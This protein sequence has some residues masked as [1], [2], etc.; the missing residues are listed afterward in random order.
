MRLFNG[1]WEKD[2]V[3]FMERHIQTRDTAV[4]EYQKKGSCAFVENILAKRGLLVWEMLVIEDLYYYYTHGQFYRMEDEVEEYLRAQIK[5]YPITEKE[6][7]TIKNVQAMGREAHRLYV[8]TLE[9]K[10]VSLSKEHETYRQKVSALRE[11]ENMQAQALLTAASEQAEMILQ[12]ARASA[13][14][15]LQNAQKEAME[16]VEACKADANV[17]ARKY[18]S[19]H[20]QQMR[21]ECGALMADY[22]ADCKENAGKTDDLHK[23]MC[24]CTSELQAAWASKLDETFDALTKLKFDLYTNLREWQNTLCGHEYRAIAQCYRDLYRILNLDKPI[25]EAIF[26]AEKHKN[27]EEGMDPTADALLK[28]EKKLTVFIRK[29]E[30]SLG[31]FGLY[32]YY[33][34]AGEE[35]NEV[36]HVCDEENPDDAVIEQCILPGVAYKE[37]GDE[38]G[39]VI[40]PAYV[41][42]RF[43]EETENET[44]ML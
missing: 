8:E 24:E 11:E 33:P 10:L 41:A 28:L 6:L 32:V 26:L 13:Q 40:L 42:V 17:L 5:P 43:R 23:K 36:L 31:D 14:E 27:D 1:N 30:Q 39:E 3:A 16:T 4:Y 20:H 29:F 22:Y 34:K 35:W 9:E 25:S 19:Q 44:N 21:A 38:D 7:L 15:I 12:S 2:K 37:K 18:L